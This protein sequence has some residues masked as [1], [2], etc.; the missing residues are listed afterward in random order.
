ML[1]RHQAREA[2]A[3]RG[4][5]ASGDCVAGRKGGAATGETRRLRGMTLA[6]SSSLRLVV[7]RGSRVHQEDRAE[8]MR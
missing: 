1:R 5:G 8:D 7:R 3:S 4:V 2:A 6:L